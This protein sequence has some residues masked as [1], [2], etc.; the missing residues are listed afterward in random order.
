[1]SSNK[2]PNH[3]PVNAMF[4]CHHLFPNNT[5]SEE[6]IFLAMYYLGSWIS[7]TLSDYLAYNNH[8]NINNNDTIHRSEAIL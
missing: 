4:L 2:V 8:I 1:M 5:E 6:F 3:R 7:V